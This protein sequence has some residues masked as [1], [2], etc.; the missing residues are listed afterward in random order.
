M[1][2]SAQIVDDTYIIPNDENFAEVAVV[3]NRSQRSSPTVPPLPLQQPTPNFATPRE[4]RRPLEE[5]DTNQNQQHLQSYELNVPYTPTGEEADVYKYYCPLCMLHF[6]SI[7]K[8]KC[9]GNY[10]CL[11]CTKDYLQTKHVYERNENISPDFIEDLRTNILLDEISCP[12]CFTQGFH[13][14]TVHTQE[15]VRDYSMKNT[16]NNSSNY[17]YPQPSPVRVGESFEDLKRKMIPF[18]V[19]SQNNSN[20]SS[21]KTMEQEK[22]SAQN[23]QTSINSSSQN[24]PALRLNLNELGNNNH[25]TLGSRPGSGRVTGIALMNDNENNGNQSPLLS[26]QSTYRSTRNSPTNRPDHTDYEYS[27][28]EAFSPQVLFARTGPLPKDEE[29]ERDLI[30]SLPQR[31]PIIKKERSLSSSIDEASES[32]DNLEDSLAGMRVLA[33]SEHYRDHQIIARDMVQGFFDTAFTSR[34]IYSQ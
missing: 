34:Q 29:E 11:F 26:P 28:N 25:L 30:S 7:L 1:H 15:K 13:I 5:L 27:S 2:A 8:S 22:L 4:N 6:Q 24:S 21:V 31:P 14:S 10:I 16:S 32:V 18:K 19:L 3:S 9:C 17:N 23:G 20:T 33:R 12:H